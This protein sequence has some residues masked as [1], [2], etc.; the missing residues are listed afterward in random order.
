MVYYQY[1]RQDAQ[2]DLEYRVLITPD[3]RTGSQVR[4][5]TAYVPALGIAADGDTVEEAHT[6]I[7]RLVVFH[8]ASL[9]K[10]GKTVPHENV[11]QEFVTTTRV[12]MPA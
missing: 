9:R 12:A 6:N 11:A 2:K 3:T 7:N 1:M 4:C 10:E 8:L 5:F